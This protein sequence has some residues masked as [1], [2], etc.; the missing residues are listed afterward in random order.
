M[1]CRL[2][3]TILLTRIIDMTYW[4]MVRAELSTGRARSQ[5]AA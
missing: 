3:G 5:G 2:G 4:G 1:I